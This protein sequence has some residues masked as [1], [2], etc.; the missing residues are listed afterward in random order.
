M[1]FVVYFVSLK[2]VCI[3]GT[4]VLDALVLQNNRNKNNNLI[5]FSLL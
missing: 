4:S 3:S 2:T 5:I 1:R